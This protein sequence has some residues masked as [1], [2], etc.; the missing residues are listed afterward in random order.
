MGEEA[1]E[2]VVRDRSGVV[3]GGV[4][5]SSDGSVG[6]NLKDVKGNNRVV[7]VSKTDGRSGL[8]LIDKTEKSRRGLTANAD[9]SLA[10]SVTLKNNPQVVLGVSVDGSP[11]IA[12]F[13]KSRK[14][15]WLAPCEGLIDA[16]AALGFPGLAQSRESR[17]RPVDLTSVKR[18]KGVRLYLYQGARRTRFQPAFPF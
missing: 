15:I 11:T 6:I 9:G 4:G 18:W 13:N 2:F 12:L 8:V 14:V 16:R 10:L 1:E 7:L 17:A 3:R 5:M